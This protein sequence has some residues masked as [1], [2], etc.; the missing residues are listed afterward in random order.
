MLISAIRMDTTAAE[1]IGVAAMAVRTVVDTA[2]M[3]TAIGTTRRTSITILVDPNAITT[4][5]TT[6]L[7]TTTC[8]L[9]AIGIDIFNSWIF[10]YSTY[11]HGHVT[12]ANCQLES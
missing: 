3:D 4:I 12:E 8:I 2:R 1:T 9:A 7:N 5:M 11:G 10:E 6:Y